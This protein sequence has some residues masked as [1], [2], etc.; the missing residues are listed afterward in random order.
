[1]ADANPECLGLRCE[2]ALYDCIEAKAGFVH[3]VMGT[4]PKGREKKRTLG[5][6][7]EECSELLISS[8]LKT[9]QEADLVPS[10]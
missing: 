2:S 1:M 5:T 7:V 3:C 6:D 4:Y 9:D 8:V 10:R